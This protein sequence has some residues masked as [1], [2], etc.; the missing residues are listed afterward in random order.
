MKEYDVATYGDRFAEIYDE[1][2]SAYDPAC[3]DL[4]AEL[5]GEGPALELGIGTGR[6]ALPLLAKGV[7]IVGIDA[8]EKMLS[9]LRAK[10]RG[11]E[12]GIVHGNFAAFKFE[13]RFRLIFVVI[14]TFFNLLSQEEQVRCFRCVS[15]HLTPDGVFVVE[16]FVPDVAR[17]IDGQTLR[18]VHVNDD[19][20]RLDISRHDPLTQQIQSQQV[21]FSNQGTR[22]YP[23]KLRYAWPSELDLMA[24]LAGLSLH[25]RWSSWAQDPFTKESKRH[26]SVYASRDSDS[27]NGA[28]S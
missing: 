3:I 12:I 27:T 4:L 28:S 21:I 16:A 5:A 19:E 10:P 14:N 22:L 25:Q 1:L 13:E 18:A 26:I 20:V 23:V 7:L 24:R 2:Y 17:F 9:Q 11:T 6:I 15:E 8:S